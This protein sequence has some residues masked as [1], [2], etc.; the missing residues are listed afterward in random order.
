[1]GRFWKWT[2]RLC[3]LGVCLGLIGFFLSVGT[4]FYYGSLASKYDLARIERML[5]QAAVDAALP[6]EI[7]PV[8]GPR[9]LVVAVDQISPHFIDALLVREDAR[10]RQHGGV[11]LLGVVRAA[12]RNLKERRMVQGA[13]TITMQVARNAFDEKERSLHRKLLEA[14]IA[15]RVEKR[16]SKDE[17]LSVY[18]SWAFLGDEY[19]GVER[20]SRA[21]FGKTA[22]Q[23]TLGEA[24]TMAGILR[25]PNR[26]SP[27]NNPE[28]AKI[29]R[30]V[31]LRRMAEAGVITEAQRDEALAE[32]LR[33]RNPHV[34]QPPKAVPFRG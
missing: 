20:A 13:G 16:F 15:R 19:H 14:M 21:W 11:D 10:F 24:A 2:K 17:I 22:R 23:I 4:L 3:F 18:S 33:A 7:P 29:Q 26:F 6:G 1:M 31:V 27:V 12:L 9:P 5:D 30:D 32:P 25:A 8:Y 28:G 34:P